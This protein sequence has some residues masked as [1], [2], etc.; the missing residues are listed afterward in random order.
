MRPKLSYA[1]VMATVAVFIALGGASYAAIKLPKNSVGAKQI[2]KNAVTG[3][4]VKDGSLTG[5]DLVASSLG[6]VN[7]ANS[8]ANADNAGELG[9]SPPSAFHDKCPAGT[10]SVTSAL[11]M[12]PKS[13]G[14]HTFLEA[15]EACAA[16][17]L[18]LPS[19]GEG[20]LM[21]PKAAPFAFWTDDFWVNKEEEQALWVLSIT[22]G[23]HVGFV[24]ETYGTFCV[25]VPTNN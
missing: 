12:T 11:C 10:V 5:A 2:K 9:G 25:A 1:N 22:G 24:E 15:A 4:K 21:A 19:P 3:A 17:G 6:T 20:L 18:R 7:R 14:N 13:I 8:A 23:L 16:E